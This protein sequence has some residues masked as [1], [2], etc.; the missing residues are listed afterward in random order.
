[1]REYF[2]VALTKAQQNVTNLAKETDPVKATLAAAAFAIGPGIFMSYWY[3]SLYVVIEGWRQ[4][5]LT[6]PKIDPLLLSPNVRFLKKYR[7]GVFHFQRNY[8]DDRFAGFIASKDSVAWVREIHS[9]F[10]RYFLE[11]ARERNKQGAQS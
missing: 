5:R 8:F 9:E 7:D 2:D 1:M 6:D 11:K 3:G 10:G 4:L